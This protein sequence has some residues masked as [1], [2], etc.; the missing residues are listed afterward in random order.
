[1]RVA[2]GG[3]PS[4]ADARSALGSGP[5]RERLR[6]AIRALAAHRGP[7]SSTCP[8]DAARAVGGDGWRDLMIPAREFARELAV[9]G[10]VVITQRGEVIDPQAQWRGPIRIQT[11]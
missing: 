4:A 10:E 5:V 2:E 8:S 11:V 9:S 6:S 1:M 3:G 7:Q